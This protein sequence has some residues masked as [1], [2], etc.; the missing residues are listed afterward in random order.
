MI[1]DDSDK[2]LFAIEMT[3]PGSGEWIRLE[4]PRPKEDCELF[5]RIGVS[6]ALVAG[7]RFR[8]VPESR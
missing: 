7:C 5:L 2:T 3:E 1:F 4:P 6:P 8:I